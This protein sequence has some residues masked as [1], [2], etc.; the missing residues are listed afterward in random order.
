MTCKKLTLTKQTVPGKELLLTYY[1]CFTGSFTRWTGITQFPSGPPPI[2]EQNL[3][4]LTE[5]YGQMSSL[6]SNHQGHNTGGNTK[7]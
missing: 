3:W 2:P 6:S 7:H 5:F 4:G 1:Y